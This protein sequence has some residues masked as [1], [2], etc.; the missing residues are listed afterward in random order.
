MKKD[1]AKLFSTLEVALAIVIILFAGYKALKPE[2][3]IDKAFY[4]AHTYIHGKTDKG[5]TIIVK[6]AAGKKLVSGKANAK[7][8][9][10]SVKVP[11]DQNSKVLTVTAK[12]HGFATTE[13]FTLTKPLYNVVPS[14][15]RGDWWTQTADGAW[16][17]QTI[18]KD[19]LSF[20][21]KGNNFLGQ[22]GGK[23]VI[24]R[25]G[26]VEKGVYVISDGQRIDNIQYVHRVP[27]TVNKVKHFALLVATK[28][29]NLMTFKYYT[30]FPQTYDLKNADKLYQKYFSTVEPK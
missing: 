30:S 3:K 12:K 23:N 26:N 16:Y 6:D 21:E 17:K 25:A 18:D 20:N 24:T 8:H 5:A 19:G 7:N 4:T 10:F 28:K 14:T 29:G 22:K 11:T 1:N 9:D 13:K 27:I 2:L 15:I